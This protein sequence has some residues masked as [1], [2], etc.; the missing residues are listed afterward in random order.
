MH[1][2]LVIV[3]QSPVA[4][5]R[6]RA[7]VLGGSCDSASLISGSISVGTS[8]GVARLEGISPESVSLLV[9]Y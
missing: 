7:S 2:N 4:L 6:G 5:F 1:S 8:S 3:G 9:L